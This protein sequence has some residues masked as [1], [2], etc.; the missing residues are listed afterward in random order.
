MITPRVRSTPGKAANRLETTRRKSLPGVPSTRACTHRWRV[1]PQGAPTSHGRCTL[2]GAER[3]FY[4]SDVPGKTDRRPSVKEMA[5]IRQAKQKDT[6]ARRI[7]ANLAGS[8][9]QTDPY[10]IQESA[11]IGAETEG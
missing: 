9:Y 11:P 5:V 2:C 7:I 10:P 3:P 6:T 4:N 1:A 8:D